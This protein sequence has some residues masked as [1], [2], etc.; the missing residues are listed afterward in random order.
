MARSK[1]L[2]QSTRQS[3][4][5]KTYKR[6]RSILLDVFGLSR[7]HQYKVMRAYMQYPSV[8]VQLL[9]SS[10]KRLTPVLVHL[11]AIPAIKGK[12]GKN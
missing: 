3:P 12:K 7:G 5:R 4:E 11:S 6:S 1:Y 10:V 9:R 8:P 2:S